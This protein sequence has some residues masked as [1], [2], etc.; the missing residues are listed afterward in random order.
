MISFEWPWVLA[1]ILP[2]LALVVYTGWRN[3]R[4]LWSINKVTAPEPRKQLTIYARKRIFWVH[5]LF[6]A[7]LGVCLILAASGIHSFEDGKLESRQPRIYL[8]LDAS[9]SMYAPDGGL[10]DFTKKGKDQTLNRMESAKKA[11]VDLLNR[12]PEA[13]FGLY[14]FSGMSN[15]H[16]LPTNDH[17]AL[18]MMIRNLNPHNIV[19]S[20]SYFSKPLGQI[21]DSNDSE[22]AFSIVMFSDGE[23]PHEDPDLLSVLERYKERGIPVHTIGVGGDEK[24]PM[25]IF[26]PDD[27]LNKLKEKRT[28]AKFETSLNEETLEMIAD[29]TDGEYHFV[30]DAEAL[31]ETLKES[32]ATVTDLDSTVK[33][34]L[35]HIFLFIA[36]VLILIEIY[37]W[38]AL[39][40]KT[41]KSAKFIL[42]VIL[43]PAMLIR[44]Q[45]DFLK[46]HYANEDGI[47]ADEES[48]FPEA[49]QFFQESISYNYRS[50][51]PRYNTGRVYYRQ[52]NY[53]KAH[54]LYQNLLVNYPEFAPAYF[55]DGMALY[56][57]GWQKMKN[58]K[59]YPEDAQKM[60]TLAVERFKS[61]GDF[62][63]EESD[64]AKATENQRTLTDRI[65]EFEKLPV[66]CPSDSGGQSSE[67]NKDNQG[68][69]NN[70]NDQNENNSDNNQ[71]QSKQDKQDQNNQPPPGMTEKE[72][73]ELNKERERIQKEMSGVNDFRQSRS[74]QMYPGQ[75]IPGQEKPQQ[76]Q[77]EEGQPE[78]GEDQNGKSGKGEE[79]EGEGEQGKGSGGGVRVFW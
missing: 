71:G 29:E 16:S 49:M 7:V 77:P 51:I 23:Q 67:N 40:V 11:A 69:Q 26:H 58:G 68:G 2:W 59:C 4:A 10:F 39:R 22:K 37:L 34:D 32:D 62:F 76:G 24:V 60:M 74:Q 13:R 30:E 41:I 31:V 44:C 47:A 75:K 66:E 42:P 61:A 21:I 53:E 28:I 14:T 3:L 36:L 55:N 17:D 50:H 25:N 48:L 63:S 19:N 33:K 79:S 9:L 6:L 1:A 57:L 78:Q 27:V 46:A 35:G 8:V 5:Y 15:L 52:K 54:D 56:E 45:P 38:P 64:I 20:G 73:D 43:L 18:K 70:E 12:I 65:Q 72:K